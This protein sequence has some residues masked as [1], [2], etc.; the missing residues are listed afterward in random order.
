VRPADVPRSAVFFACQLWLI[1]A[2]AALVATDASIRL[3]DAANPLAGHSRFVIVVLGLAVPAAIGA[4]L[5]LTRIGTPPDHQRQKWGAFAAA[6][7]ALLACGIGGLVVLGG[8]WLAPLAWFLLAGLAIALVVLVWT[9]GGGTADTH[10][11]LAG[12]LRGIWKYRLLLLI[13][14][15]YNIRSRYSQTVLGILWIVLLPLSTALVLSFLFS[16]ITHPGDIGNAPFISFFLT[17]LTFWG[18][19]SSGVNMGVR[20]LLGSMGLINQVYFPREVL[21]LVRFC[22]ELV[23]LSFTIVTLLVVN[24]VVG[25]WPNA[26]YV[27]LPLALFIQMV[28][29]LG[30]MFLVSYASVLVRDVPQL[31]GVLLQLFFYLTPIIYPIQT[32]PEQLRW[33]TFV[34]PLASLIDAYRR[35]IVYGQAPML[36]T[37]LYPAVFAAVLLFAGFMSF[38]KFEKYISDYK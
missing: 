18:L 32:A 19:F 21:I 20:A 17:A 15:V 1:A 9:P 37:L 24:A 31:I 14:T 26:W 25:I 28:L 38:K 12:Y 34:N 4:S 8:A 23:D 30:A 13:W 33:L 5:V 27:M 36:S 6:A 7:G 22:E 3:P 11:L 35:I 10:R 29:T 16:Q 2:G